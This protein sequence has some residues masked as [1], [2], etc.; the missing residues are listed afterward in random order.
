MT[1]IF[2]RAKKK[3]SVKVAIES[4]I[5]KFKSSEIHIK[6]F[7]KSFSAV[8]Q[9]CLFSTSIYIRKFHLV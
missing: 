6:K 9:I 7:S 2:K 3:K 4:F 5:K 8:K 1:H